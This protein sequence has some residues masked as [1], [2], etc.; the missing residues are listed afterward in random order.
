MKLYLVGYYGYK[1]I[2]DELLLLWLLSY[3]ND[4]YNPT[5]ISVK[6]WDVK[7][8]QSWLTKHKDLLV[9][10]W[11]ETPIDTVESIPYFPS[12]NDLLIL[13][14][15]E[16]ITDARSF[17]YNGWNHFARY[18]PYFLS[19]KV[20]IAWG[21]WTIKKPRTW[22]LY[23][24]IFWHSTGVVV[25]E[26]FSFD[27]VTPFSDKVT[28]HRDFA[29]DVLEKISTQNNSNWSKYVIINL[30][31]HIWNKDLKK[32]ITDIYN[33]YQKKWVQVYYI[34]GAMWKDDSD[35]KIYHQLLVVCKNLELYNRTNY[36]LPEI[37]W[38]ISGASKWYVTRLHI[39]LLCDYYKVPIDTIV[40]QEKVDRFLSKV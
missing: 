31:N 20:V 36:T 39:A 10:L 11:V 3:F 35:M 17:P 24:L 5:S 40:Y 25:R 16:V 18:L 33:S 14:W 2:W 19:K 22:L 26:Q 6:S 13:G 1:N 29:Y 4:L 7:W 38:F 8:L 15:W 32:K 21:I 12:K 37:C 30:N 23:K 27:I 9:E 34:A 28:L